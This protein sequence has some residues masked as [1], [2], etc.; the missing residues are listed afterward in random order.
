MA[1]LSAQGPSAVMNSLYFKKRE[2][3]RAGGVQGPVCNPALWMVLGS[4]RNRP[5]SAQWCHKNAEALACQA[6]ASR[7]M[8]A[9]IMWVI[10]GLFAQLYWT[11]F[12]TITTD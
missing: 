1:G 9:M 7:G 12:S 4:Q 6:R 2:A 5:A 3:E 10:S 11:L 8:M